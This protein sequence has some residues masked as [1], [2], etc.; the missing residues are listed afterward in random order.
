[1]GEYKRALAKDMKNGRGL[2]GEGW[3]KLMK[4][5]HLSTRAYLLSNGPGP[6]YPWEVVQWMETR[7]TSTGAYD[8]AFS[9]VSVVLVVNPVRHYILTL[10]SPFSI[11]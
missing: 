11:R 5:D 2:D 4:V 10:G 7:D 8:L 6:G 1:M 3:M 9:E